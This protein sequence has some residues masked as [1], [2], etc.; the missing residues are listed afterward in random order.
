MTGPLQ[1]QWGRQRQ[2]SLLAGS[3]CSC[4]RVLMCHLLVCPLRRALRRFVE[5]PLSKGILAG[6]FPEGSRVMV[7]ADEQGL[8]FERAEEPVKVGT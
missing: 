4:A 1:W 5:N 8:T 6:D 2:W 7:G 3:M